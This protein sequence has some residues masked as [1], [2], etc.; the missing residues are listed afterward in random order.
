MDKEGGF[1]SHH[2]SQYDARA[3]AKRIADDVRAKV[4]ARLASRSDD[5]L[6]CDSR[7]VSLSLSPNLQGDCPPSLWAQVKEKASTFVSTFIH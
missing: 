2:G 6:V 5:T 1:L 7:L 4:C 3:L